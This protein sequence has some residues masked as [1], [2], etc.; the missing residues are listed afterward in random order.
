MDA[1]KVILEHLRAI[2]GTLDRHADD[3]RESKSRLGIF[4]SQHAGPLNR[5]DGMDDRVGR[6]EKPPDL[7]DA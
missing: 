4:K 6:I 7:L 1:D 2:P 5:L 3:P